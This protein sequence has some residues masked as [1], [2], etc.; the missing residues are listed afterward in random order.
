M[1]ICDWTL[2][3][4]LWNAL[5]TWADGDT[6]GAVS[7]ISPA[8]ELY[9]DCRALSDTGI[10][11]RNKDIGGIAADYTFYLRFK[12]DVWDGEGEGSSGNGIKIVI[13]GASQRLQFFIAN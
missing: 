3:N 7:S 11:Y 12:G 13:D 9:L 6:N 1:A 2:L 10:A 5:G 8:G 4:E